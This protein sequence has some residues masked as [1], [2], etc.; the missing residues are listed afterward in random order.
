MA[1][2]INIET[3]IKLGRTLLSPNLVVPLYVLS[4]YTDKGR[5]LSAAK[6]D[7]AKWIRLIA[8]LGVAKKVHG[9]FNQGL[10]NNFKRD[11]YAWN[12][13]IAVV[14]GGSDGIGAKVS[15][16]LAER[17]VRVAVLDIKPP[18]YTTGPNIHFI[19]CD[20]TSKEDIKA[21]ATEIRATFGEPTILVNNAGILPGTTLLG[22]SDELTRKVFEINT[23]S[24]YTLAREFLPH[25]V[26]RD[27]GMVVTVASQ[28]GFITLPG[29]IDY[30]GSKSAA[31]SFHEGLN[32]ELRARYKAPRVRTVLLAPGFIKTTLIDKLTCFDSFVNPLLDPEDVAKALTKQIFS[33]ESGAVYLPEFSSS[34]AGRLMRAL[35]VWC[36]RII[37]ACSE[38]LTHQ[39]GK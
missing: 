39:S 9:L 7:L 28:A 14:T 21:A 34:F 18:V 36:Q 15:R 32:A 24:H 2:I 3:L 8:I 30:S 17:G 27:H 23:L 11:K 33:G 31:I 13:E 29:M 12:R 38:D 4:N 16:I 10:L 20:I 26:K 6:P 22:S 5:L 35:P 37:H 25:M 19:K 1:S